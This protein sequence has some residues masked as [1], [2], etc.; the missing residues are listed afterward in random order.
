M[1]LA[2]LSMAL[3][4]MRNRKPTKK[5]ER[6]GLRFVIDEEHCPHCHGL[7]ESDLSAFKKKIANEHRHTQK[8]GNLMLF[9]A[10]VL[11]V[12]MALASI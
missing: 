11:L 8:L 7:S 1:R 6:C 9:G 3:A 10:L 12:L 5:C 4:H 2:G